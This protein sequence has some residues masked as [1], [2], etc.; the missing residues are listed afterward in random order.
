MSHRPKAYQQSYVYFM[1]AWPSKA[2]YQTMRS[3]MKVS[4]FSRHLRSNTQV[5][6]A[7][8]LLGYSHSNTSTGMTPVASLVGESIRTNGTFGTSHTDTQVGVKY[9][10]RYCTCCIN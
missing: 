3:R 4:Q 7:A 8:I 6:A 2:G 9:M 10:N 1:G 5:T